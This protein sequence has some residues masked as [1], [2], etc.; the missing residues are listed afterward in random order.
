MAAHK[1]LWAGKVD[2]VCSIPRWDVWPRLKINV[3]RGGEGLGLDGN[4]EGQGNVR[5]ALRKS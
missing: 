5:E 4:H 3:E 2:E 1:G